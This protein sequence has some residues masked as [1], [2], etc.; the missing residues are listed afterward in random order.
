M[1]A[2]ARHPWFVPLWS[3]LRPS[4]SLSAMS[5]A[6]LVRRLTT[7]VD[8][9]V[10]G[11][12]AMSA[13]DEE[14]ALALLGHRM[15]TAEALVAHHRGRVFKRT[16]D[17]L[18]AEFASP[19]EAVRAALEIQDA[20]RS[21]N[22]VEGADDQ[23]VLRIGINLGDV[24]ESGD[25]LM[26]DAV[27][28]AARLESIAAPGGVCVSAAVYEQI[29]GKLM[30]S[31]EDMGE[32]HV[33]NIPRA[34][35]A[36]RLSMGDARPAAVARAPAQP[37]VRAISP[38]F[39]V[40]VFAIGATVAILAISGAWLLHE[41]AQPLPVRAPSSRVAAAP[42]SAAARP[43]PATDNAQAPAAAPPAAPTA[44][45]PPAVPPTGAPPRRYAPADV[46]FVPDW[47][48]ERLANYAAAEGEKALAIN[49]RGLFGA[50]TR[51]V[52]L[53][54][55]RQAALEEC[56]RAVAREVPVVR[57]FDACMIYAEGDDVVWPYRAPPMPPPP[58]LPAKRPSP[59]IALDPATV[60]LIGEAARRNL[61]EHY[62]RANHRRAL[63]LGRRH[64]AWW[65]PNANDGDAVRRNLQI[66]GHITGFPC[67]VYAVDDQV[68]VRVPALYNV[69]DI[70]VPEHL[71]IV[72]AGQAAAVAR[73]LV[74][75][76]WRAIA[77]A[78]NGR[79][80]IVTDRP[81]ERAA[82]DA[83][84]NECARAG[85]IDCTVTAVGPFLV[86][87]L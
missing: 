66:C 72:D 7:I 36:Y 6:S 34:I 62:L 20:M 76:D 55:A 19:V 4:A 81:G 68:M 38:R 82:A 74:A 28:V 15:A 39:L 23:L 71:A 45:S 1:T 60:P 79:L 80:G 5:E 65:T 21:A 83:A 18:L 63:V 22:E 54:A 37:G 52:D 70:F 24:V 48:H 41:W 53:A 32:Q 49:V 35:H 31:A 30:L 56:N 57:D 85:G 86:A 11:F 27:N 87:P 25:D 61:F 8:L 43:V 44:I 9:D 58:F 46:P 84:L 17:G 2:E 29:E 50:A 69:V 10:V 26:G 16:G 75:D 42:A 77:V 14:H 13:R 73:Y 59:P 3:L 78:S 40:G 33:K 47:R 51:R 67:V 12:S 64:F